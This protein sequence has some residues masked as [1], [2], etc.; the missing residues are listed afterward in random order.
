MLHY[1]LGFY[2]WLSDCRH[3]QDI[4]DIVR[5]ADSGFRDGT[6]WTLTASSH[7]YLVS[8]LSALITYN[9][10][11]YI[12]CHCLCV[13]LYLLSHSLYKHNSNIHSSSNAVFS[14]CTN[15]LGSSSRDRTLSSKLM[16]SQSRQ[17]PYHTSR[18]FFSCG[19]SRMFA[20]SR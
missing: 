5:V 16:P 18:L 14:R 12:V 8:Q 7:F 1:H 3:A 20:A 19:C 11:Q 15:T 6:L 9:L 2:S 4:R 17:S 10:V 13:S